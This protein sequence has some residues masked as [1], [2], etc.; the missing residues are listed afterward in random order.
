MFQIQEEHL[1]EMHR[2]ALDAYPEECCGIVIG[3]GEDTA[4]DTLFRCTN[5]QNR[6]HAA[7]PEAHPRDAK[8]AYF[9]DE[10][11]LLTITRRAQDEGRVIKLFYHSHP[12]HDAYFSEEDTR[13]ALFFDEPAYPDARYLVISVYNKAIKDQAL[14]EWSEGSRTF[15]Q[16]SLASN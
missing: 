10:K 14:F 11:E 2:H 13:R 5:I 12:E 7:D 16:V 1:K 6:L 4:S 15:E 3:N 9:I 8:T